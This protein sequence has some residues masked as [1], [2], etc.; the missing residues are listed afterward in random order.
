VRLRD[1]GQTRR[2]A[3]PATDLVQPEQHQRQ[4]AEDDEEELHDFVVDGA[5]QSTQGDVDQHDR[6]GYQDAEVEWPADQ[7]LEQGGEREQRY[8]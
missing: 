4:E 2:Q 1:L 5:G 7:G 8:P 6:P 3:M